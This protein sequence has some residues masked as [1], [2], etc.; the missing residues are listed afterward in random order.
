MDWGGIGGGGMEGDFE[1][2]FGNEGGDDEKI[3]LET[4]RKEANWMV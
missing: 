1:V 3:C 2:M 4:E